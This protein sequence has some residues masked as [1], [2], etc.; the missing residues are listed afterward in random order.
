MMKIA[1]IDV[2]VQNTFTPV[3]PQELPVPE[4][5]LIADALNAQAKLAD[6]RVMTKM[7]IR[8]RLRGW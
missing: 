3:C 4:G 7:R 5:H 1:A 8:R 6:Y 2:D